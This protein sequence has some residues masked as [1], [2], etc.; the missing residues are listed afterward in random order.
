MSYVAEPATSRSTRVDRYFAVWALVLPITSVLVI[1]FVQGT[2]PGFMLALMVPAVL[3]L[4]TRHAG[5]RYYLWMMASL[6]VVLG[7]A[8]ASQLSLA[9]SGVS[10]LSGVR[11][12]DPH[13]P[14]VMLRSSLFTQ[15]LYLL[16]AL[17]TFCFV[18]HFYR[19]AWD[20]YIFAGVLLLAGY[21]LYE[22]VFYLLTGTS[23]DFLSNRTF[24]DGAAGSGS[25]FQTIALGPVKLQRVKSLT[26]EPSMYAFTV[27][28][29]WIYALHTGR[30]RTALVLLATLLL[31]T[32]TTAVLGILAYLAFRF[33]TYGPTDRG[34][35]AVVASSLV[36]FALFSETFLAVLD[37]LILA[38]L[39]METFSGLDRFDSLSSSIRFFMEAPL[40]V[41]LVGI[42][43]GY[44]RSIDM[45][46]TLLVNTGILG[47]LLFSSL[48]LAP[49]FLL[50]RTSEERGLKA[51]VLVIYVTM[52][53]A[54]AEY[55]YLPVWLFLG[56]AYRTLANRRRAAAAGVEADADPD[57][58]S[59][60]T[61]MIGPASPEPT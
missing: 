45:F 10:Y 61:V 3:P 9:F 51:A 34:V 25:L 38:K 27:L 54:V 5:Q 55:M 37:N 36:A 2:T 35:L 41:Q 20:R 30:R 33:F 44:I 49:L 47:F 29:F 19:R 24:G 21:G 57:P 50:G 40:P 1:P 52:M 14:S 53:I 43:F 26:G 6:L 32:S 8:A 59:P 7:F 16:A 15:T 46:G 23:G 4:L 12:V 42:G 39:A 60:R 58:G 18:A 28:P 13:D 22:W 11:L 48:F 17:S 31:S 56:M